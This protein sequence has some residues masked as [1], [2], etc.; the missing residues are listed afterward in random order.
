VQKCF[1]CGQY[2]TCPEDDCTNS[3]FA[4]DKCLQPGH[5]TEDCPRNKKLKRSESSST[6]QLSPV[7]PLSSSAPQPSQEIKA[8]ANDDSFWA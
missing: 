7:Q 1:R 4:C 2:Q 5:A 6:T 8:K 3:A